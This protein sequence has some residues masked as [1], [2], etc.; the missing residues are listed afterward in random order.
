MNKDSMKE[1]LESQS[2]VLKALAGK[3]GDFYLAGGTALANYHLQHHRESYDLDFFA[4]QY[5]P[6]RVDEIAKSISD[7][8][9]K[10]MRVVAREE[11]RAKFADIRR[12]D[13]ILDKKTALRIDFVRDVHDRLEPLMEINGIQ[14]L[15]LPDIYLRKIYAVTG[16]LAKPD[17]TGRMITEG[18]RQTA[19]DLF[20]LYHLSTRYQ[21]L[22]DFAV[23]Y[24]DDMQIEGLCNWYH[25]FDR[26]TIKTELLEIRTRLP[27]EFRDMDRHFL[28]EINRLYERML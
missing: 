7:Q 17:A 25:S 23:K 6:S 27:L 10:T 24:C 8:L 19:R 28:I 4:Q 13:L 1:I 26:M 3:L 14:V 15:S 16:V 18:G 20:D 2:A 12:Y 11:G 22:S 9:K 5:N 21:P